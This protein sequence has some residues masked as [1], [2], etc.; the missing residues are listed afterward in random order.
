MNALARLGRKLAAFF[1]DDALLGGA[2]VASVLVA[3]L[4]RALVGGRPLVAGCVLAGGCLLAL[5]LSV[6]RAAAASPATK[7]TPM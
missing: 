1:V 4:C 2:T 3:T 7:P 6:A 5:T